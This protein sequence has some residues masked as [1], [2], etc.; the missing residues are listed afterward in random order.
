M[1]KLSRGQVARIIDA[2]EPGHRSVYSIA[3]EHGI[4]PQWVRVLWRRSGHGRTVPAPGRP[5]RPRKGVPDEVRRRILEAE[6]TYRLHPRALE[7]ILGYPHNTIWAVLKE[8]GLVTDTVSLQR[9]RKPWVRFERRFSNSLW[10]AD[11][12]ELAPGTWLLVF[13]DDAS[14]KIV[15][16]AVTRHATAELAWNTFVAAAARH[17]FPR[18]ILTDHGIQFTHEPQGGEGLLDRNLR[19]LERERRV[20]V[21]HIMGRVNHPQTGGK[22]ERVFGTIK[23]KLRARWPDGTRQFRDVDEVIPWYNEVKPHESLDWETPAEAFVR[24]LRPQEKRA[25]RKRIR[26]GGR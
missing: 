21:K 24:K 14:R 26:R 25:Y 2:M 12:T 3:R 22:V 8:A 11:F 10:Q 23:G 16:Y 1:R 20:R 5:G 6:R 17:G 9:R 19:A 13:L 7:Q 4:T 18:Q 15:G